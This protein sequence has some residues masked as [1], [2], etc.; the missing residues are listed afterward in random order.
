[1]RITMDCTNEPCHWGERANR[2]KRC[3]VVPIRIR[4]YEYWLAGKPLKDDGK[5]IYRSCYLLLLGC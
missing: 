4:L 2:R 1:M 5:S 3:I